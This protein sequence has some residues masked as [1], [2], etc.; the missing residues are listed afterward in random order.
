MKME[1]AVA[2]VLFE[3]KYYL[4]L[5]DEYY[6]EINRSRYY[7]LRKYMKE[8]GR[9]FEHWK[10]RKRRRIN[11]KLYILIDKKKNRILTK[12]Y[13][14]NPSLYEEIY[15]ASLT[16]TGVEIGERIKWCGGKRYYI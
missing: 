1:V 14:S 2:K 3:K 8:K 11:M 4:V 12:K 6:I 15:K 16:K 5:N 13:P 7:H 9:N 10:T